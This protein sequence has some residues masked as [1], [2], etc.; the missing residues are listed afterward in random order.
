[1]QLFI[2]SRDRWD[3]SPTVDTMPAEAMTFVTVMVP[4]D[5]YKQYRASPNFKGLTIECWPDYVDCVPKKRRY[6]YEKVKGAYMV[7]D[8]DLGIQV[9]SSRDQKYVPANSKPTLFMSKLDRMWD[10]LDTADIGTV[11]AT[12][13]FMASKRIKENGGQTVWPGLVPFCFAGF[14]ADRPKIKW[15][16]FF[17]TDIAMPMQIMKQGGTSVTDFSIAYSMRNNKKLQTTGTSV[18][19]DEATIKYSAL[20]LAKTVPGHVFGLKDTGNNGGGW[21]LQKTF[22][23]PNLSRSNQWISGFLDQEGLTHVPRTVD[24]TLKTPM[25]EL[26]ANYKESW[27]QA[28]ED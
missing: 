4:K 18:Y 1:V 15:R 24:L 27:E 16:T 8:D 12:N 26:F 7:I 10:R 13:T 25:A 11:G 6:L 3:Y 20:A 22:T 21:S 19:R 23:R 14:G 5:Q 2:L 17:F 28:Q 9:W